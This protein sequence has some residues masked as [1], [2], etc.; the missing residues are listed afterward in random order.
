MTRSDIPRDVSVLS[1]SQTFVNPAVDATPDCSPAFS[2][3]TRSACH[4]GSDVDRRR[5]LGL[6]LGDEHADRRRRSQQPRAARRRQL[7]ARRRRAAPDP[8]RLRPVLRAHSV[9][10]LLRHHLQQ[11]GRRRH[12]G[13]LRA[14]HAIRPAGVPDRAAGRSI[15]ATCRL[16]SCR[17]ATCRCSIRTCAARATDSSR[18]GY[19]SS[20]DR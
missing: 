19:V 12:L 2:P 8:R 6:R 3:R 9:R 11:S 20:S 5:A 15:R 10:R 4:T 17:R 18:L 7:D 14:R 13:H 16:G 1:Y